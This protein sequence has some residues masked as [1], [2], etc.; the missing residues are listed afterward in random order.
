MYGFRKNALKKHAQVWDAS[1]IDNV[2][3][4]LQERGLLK[5]F[6]ILDWGTERKFLAG[7]SKNIDGMEV[8]LADFS[9]MV[10]LAGNVHNQSRKICFFPFQML[11]AVTFY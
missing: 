7:L 2:E 6:D 5:K 8:V 9:S 4:E 10:N 1:Y 3:Y 11:V